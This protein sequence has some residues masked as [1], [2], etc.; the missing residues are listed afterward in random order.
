VS[1]R[2]FAPVEIRATE[3]GVVT[4]LAAPYGA[5]AA[6]HNDFLEQFTVDSFAR[7]VSEN[8]S[9]IPLMALHDYDTFP[10]GR[11]TDWEHTE[12]GL[13]GTWQIDVEST[14]GADVLRRMREGFITGLSVG[15]QPDK[16]ADEKSVG[17]D[18]ITRVVR[19]NAR[20]LEVSAVSVPAYAEAQIMAV[21]TAGAPRSLTTT[22]VARAKFE[23]TRANHQ[24][25]TA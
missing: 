7:S 15:F 11:S 13:V 18:G 3:D 4:G 21:R 17:D 24:R 25:L 12:K 10:V 20:L 14:E 16:S 2:R 6:I 22:E 1:E 5:W 19:R 9:S 8:P 23:A